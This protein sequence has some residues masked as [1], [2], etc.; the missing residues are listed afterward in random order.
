VKKA[1]TD[2]TPTEKRKRSSVEMRIEALPADGIAR[3]AGG[4][5]HDFNNLLTVVRNCT[6][7]LSME[8]DPDDPRQQYVDQLVTAAHRM[9]QVARQLQAF[10]RGQ[11]MQAEDVRPGELIRRMTDTLRHVLPE[12]V[13]FRVSVRATSCVVH[14][15]PAQLERAVVDVLM[16]VA[17]AV[18]DGGR[19]WLT[20][21]DEAI[22]APTPDLPAGRYVKI[23][24]ANTAPKMTEAERKQV[25]LPGFRN[26][27]GTTGADLRLASAYGI[28]KQAGGHM[29]TDTERDR[30]VVFNIYLPI[31]EREAREVVRL[32]ATEQRSLRGEEIILVVEDDPSVRRTVC[33]SLEQYGYTVFEAQ[34]GADAL[35]VSDH[36]ST[37]PDL[38]L[39]DVVMPDV[40]GRELIEGLAHENRLPKVLLMSGYT[41]AILERSLPKT[42]YP[43][44]PKPFTHEELAERVRAVLDARV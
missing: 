29:D 38:L 25:F 9:G 41:D 44:I 18:A 22:E 43:F 6:S 4:I 7:F 42:R 40:G 21:S 14:V 32:E 26:K 23:A 36:L 19:V 34:D 31:V 28:V 11:F 3:L 33:D 8:M 20:V 37:L 30:G 13:D 15:D 39:T 2:K 35:R 16:Y 10:G 24:V 17:D 27:R 1:R 12:T 5:A